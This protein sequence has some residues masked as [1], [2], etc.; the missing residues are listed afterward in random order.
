VDEEK[1][2]MQLVLINQRIDRIERSLA[3]R[4]LDRKPE[5][6]TPFLKRKEAVDLLA[7]R[8]L[9]ERCERAGWLKAAIRK[10]RLVLYRRTDVMACFYRISQ[11]EYP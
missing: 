2:F 3:S 8:S 6:P 9:L 10:P 5:P 11:G 1:L 4:K 7:T